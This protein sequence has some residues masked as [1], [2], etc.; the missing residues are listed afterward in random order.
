MNG[1]SKNNYNLDGV[2]DPNKII[3]VNSET[4]NPDV[5]SDV[6]MQ[7]RE[8][9]QR[10]VV[11]GRNTIRGN[12]DPFC[13]GKT[14]GNYPDPN[15]CEFFYQCSLTLSRRQK[16]APGTVFNSEKNMCD[17][18]SEVKG[19]E[20]YFHQ[21]KTPKEKKTVFERMVQ[22]Y[23]TA[24]SKRSYPRP[25]P[26]AAMYTSKEVIVP[27]DSPS[28]QTTSTTPKPETTTRKPAE[29]S[30]NKSEV[31]MVNLAVKNE[32]KK[33]PQKSEK[34]GNPIFK[35][36]TISGIFRSGLRNFVLRDM[37]RN[38]G[39]NR[40]IVKETTTRKTTTTTT[41]AQPTS[42]RKARSTDSLSLLSPTKVSVVA[43][44]QEGTSSKVQN[45]NGKVTTGD[46]P[47]QPFR[48]ANRNVVVS[49]YMNTDSLSSRQLGLTVFP[50]STPIDPESTTVAN[51]RYTTSKPR[52]VGEAL[53]KA[54]DMASN[55]SIEHLLATAPPPPLDTYSVH[56]DGNG[57]AR[58]I[59]VIETGDLN[60]DF[61]SDKG[62]LSSV[63]NSYNGLTK[64]PSLR[65]SIEAKLKALTYLSSFIKSEKLD[66]IL[67]DTLRKRRFMDKMSKKS[68]SGFR[69]L[70]K[71]KKT[72]Y[73]PRLIVV[74]SMGSGEANKKLLDRFEVGLT[75]NHPNSLL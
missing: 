55:A 10:N 58:K 2:V 49:E 15:F 18:P 51:M 31:E 71:M 66:Q 12:H 8:T 11:I 6:K 57:N 52:S 19:C 62:F 21:N 4:S 16:C 72:V 26:P 9:T 44:Y 74:T 60:G 30:I 53:L 43:G 40:H 64:D 17:F 59:P 73:Y 63:G 67:Q 61:G 20:N 38:Q 48:K 22:K 45:S 5:S 13:F 41:T 24:H 68:T 23:G 56:I 32:A 28:E 75:S 39:G 33:T 7:R 65:A 27:E 69:T 54:G 50:L 70:A 29:Q 35:E 47:P 36:M 34:K 14:I 37:L 25:P 46:Q 3:I 1:D 42:T